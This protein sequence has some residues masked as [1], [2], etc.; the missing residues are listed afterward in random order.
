MDDPR[1]T[2]AEIRNTALSVDEVLQAVQDPVAG[3]IGLFVG[4]VRDHDQNKGVTGLDYS[5]HPSAADELRKVAGEVLSD[6]IA[7]VAAV[8]RVGPLQVGDLAVVVAVSAPHR[9]AA[10]DVCHTLIDRLKQT[11]PIWK[12][13]SFTDGSDEWVGL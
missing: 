1:V 8:H 12:H 4:V 6:E 2:L 3:G 9:A 10:L 7:K 11:A 13:Q 5:A